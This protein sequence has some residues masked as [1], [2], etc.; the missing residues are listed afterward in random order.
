M[1]FIST[2]PEEIKSLTSELT[3]LRSGNMF[4]N[5]KDIDGIKLIT[6]SAGEVSVDELIGAQKTGKLEECFGTGTAA[7][8]SPVGKLRYKDE[9]M[10][11][12]DGEIGPVSAKIYDE[13]TGIQGGTKEDKLNWITFV[14]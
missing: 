13:I 4:E 10:V 1:T 12:S 11:I 14:D 3:E 7:V 5:A 6:A 2:F 9:V 8:I